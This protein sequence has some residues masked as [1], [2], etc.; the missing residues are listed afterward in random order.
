[1][2]EAFDQLA[3]RKTIKMVV[4]NKAQTVLQLFINELD[5]A[6]HEFDNMKRGVPIPIG[7]GKYSG[8][9]IWVRGLIHRIEKMKE[10]VDKVV[11]VDEAKKRLPLEKYDQVY[12]SMRQFIVLQKLKDW[13]DENKELED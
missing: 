12:T 3:K 4:S 10:W 7:H 11:F 2:L 5:A 1:M 8:Q 6:K 9:A 13:K